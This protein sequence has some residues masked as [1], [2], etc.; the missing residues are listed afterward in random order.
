MSGEARS[1]E[2]TG[3]V[4]TA[5]G[6]AGTEVTGYAAGQPLY[7]RHGWQTVLPL[8]A[9]RK[10]A[11]PRGYTGRGA[12]TP[13]ARQLATWR[14]RHLDG[15]LALHLPPGVLGI[16]VDAYGGKPGA[17]TLAELEDRLGALPDTWRSSSRPDDPVSGIRF[18]RVPEGL[19]WPGGL[20]GIELIH[21]GHRYAVVAP[22]IHPEGRRY[23]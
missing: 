20:P 10:E 14:Q 9:G 12:K 22:S 4:G 17:E 18:F 2:G 15:N 19:E 8:P 1:P 3:S 16:D 13:T 5:L 23:R 21:S 7:E 6:G 11:P